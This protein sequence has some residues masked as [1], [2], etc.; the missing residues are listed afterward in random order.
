MFYNGLVAGAALLT[1]LAI[2]R[3]E[4]HR[5]HGVWAM[6]LI[7]LALQIKPTVVFEGAWFGFALLIADWRHRSRPTALI[8]YALTLAGIALVPTLIAYAVYVGI[9]HGEAWWFANI[10][11][12]FLRVTPPGE[13]IAG[14]LIGM[15]LNLLIPAGAAWFGVMRSGREARWV[16]GG[17]LV[18]AVMGVLAIPPYFNHYALPLVVPIAVLA[19]VGM[20]RSRPFAILVGVSAAALLLLSGYPHDGQRRAAR[21]QVAA[22]ATTID[23]YRGDGCLFAFSAPPV[24]YEAT[25]SCLPTRYPFGTHLTLIS[26]AGAIGVDPIAELRRILATRPPVIVTGPPVGPVRRDPYAL[27]AAAL[28]RD[29]VA[30]GSGLGYRVYARRDRI[31]QAATSR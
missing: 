20:A 22:L 24:L 28:M 26:E 3:P 6:L 17:W 11:S 29:Y 23:R 27:V 31:A 10:R 1:W 25:G 4:S 5:R 2:V 18:A 7:G 13:P 15:A 12:I 8:G 14:R 21:L 30:V 9:G 16:I 19:G